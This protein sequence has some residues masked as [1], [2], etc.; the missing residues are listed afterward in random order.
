[1][2][3]DTPPTLSTM[4]PEYRDALYAQMAEA[5]GLP[6]PSSPSVSEP[7]E[8]DKLN[9]KIA[10]QNPPA[11]ISIEEYLSRNSVPEPVV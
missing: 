10:K 1:M 7:T 9:A 2:A 5:Q 6:Q 11:S 8:A 4:T 3:Q